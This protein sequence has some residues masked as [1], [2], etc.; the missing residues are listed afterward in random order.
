VLSPC[1]EQILLYKKNEQ[2]QGFLKNTSLSFLGFVFRAR[3][4]GRTGPWDEAFLPAGPANGV[5]CARTR[6][7]QMA[8]SFRTDPQARRYHDR[9]SHSSSV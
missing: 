4:A 1:S 7:S 2:C 9:F 8:P 6:H 3:I 5:A